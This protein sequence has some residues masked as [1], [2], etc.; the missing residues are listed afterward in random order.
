[1]ILLVLSLLAHNIGFSQKESLEFLS[2]LSISRTV[3]TTTI[4]NNSSILKQTNNIQGTTTIT[5]LLA[6]NLE[7]HLQ[8]AGAVLNMTSR[9][10]EV[11]NTSF[12]YFLN[13]T[14]TTLHGI[15]KVADVQKRQIAQ[16]ILSNFKD[17]QI[18]FFLMPNGNIYLKEP[19]SRQQN[20][21]TNNLAFRHY[22]QV[23]I[24]TH[25]IYL[26]NVITST[27]SGQREALIAVPIYSGSTLIGIWTGGINF[28]VLNNELQ[29]LNL[30]PDQ[31]VVYVDHNGQKLADSN[32]SSSNKLESF[33][34]LQSFKDAIN[35]KSGSDIEEVINGNTSSKMFV[36]Y[37]PVKAFQNTWAVLLIQKVK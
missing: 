5:R 17:L 4:N 20:S 36:N 26:G 30:P 1:M 14:L 15:P 13:K 18:V 11:N 9:L 6:N 19:Y 22:F 10:P 37:Q 25:N 8:N 31:R 7:N 29:S 24:K 35:G 12:A 21:T 23:S 3:I 33:A 16:N 32:L 34:N 2:P 28:N 27:S